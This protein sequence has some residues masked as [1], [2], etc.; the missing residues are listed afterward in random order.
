MAA[1]RWFVMFIC[2]VLLIVL[3]VVLP[4]VIVDPFGAFGDRFIKWNSYDMTN[5]P[6]VA[7]FSYIDQRIGDYDAFI[8]GPSG[9]SGFLPSTLEKYTGLRW[10]NMF[11]YGADLEYT[12]RLAEYL[13]EYHHPKQ[14]LLCVPIVS[15][16][17][18][19]WS[20]GQ[21]P[22]LQPLAPNWRIP[23]YFANPKYAINKIKLISARSYVQQGFDVFDAETGTYNKTRRDA[24]AI[25][26]MDKYLEVYPEFIKISKVTRLTHTDE[27]IAAVAEIKALC[28]SSGTDLIIT[29]CPMYVGDMGN[30][31]YQEVEYFLEQLALVS[32]Y[33]DFT[34]SSISTDPRYFYDEWHFRNSV[35]E[36][37]VA[38]VF[39]DDSAYIPGDL[40]IF[41][42]HGDA[43]RAV[44]AFFK[45]PVA[46]DGYVRE[47]PILS[48]HSIL[49][50][51]NPGVTVSPGQFEEQMRALFDAGYSAVSLKQMR[52]FV[53]TGAPLP[54]KAVAITFD[55]GYLSN[56]E[57]AFPVLKKYAFNAA[58]F[59]IGVSFGQDTYKDTGDPIYPHFGAEEARE[60]VDSG[61]ISIQ[62]HTYDLHQ[63]EER[64]DPF[65]KGVLRMD[66]ESEEAYLAVLREDHR[67]FTELLAKTTGEE[68]FALSYPYSQTSIF[69]SIAMR[70]M[71]ISMTFSLN[72]GVAELI[73]GLP[74]SLLELE[75]INVEWGT[76]GEQLL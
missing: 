72:H 33:W 76:S 58:I 7:K 48:Y 23:Y 45:G 46:E 11:N 10:Y 9:S 69:S 71:G 21:L 62:S 14:M 60:M 53:L 74:Q 65:R 43:S 27:C 40:G 19:K 39:G 18:Y 41:V 16:S 49:E 25:G 15:G 54:E 52:D 31:D 22:N 70:E 12:K 30:Y 34:I 4:N 66:G 20:D 2:A 57:Y 3:A 5:N 59:M 37:M 1:R 73:K 68:L 36:M 61:L 28:D 63:V 64:D 51:G 67:H 8:I 55:D 47:I 32:D 6:K 56:Y 42:S 17:T 29:T 75:R 50:E 38:R 24:E 13:V 26:H 35:G 44:E